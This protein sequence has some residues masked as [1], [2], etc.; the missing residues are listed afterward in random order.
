MSEPADPKQ[1]AEMKQQ[2]IKEFMSL[3]PLTLEIAGLPRVEPGKHFN[4]DQM[5][6]RSTT[7]KTAYKVARGLI[8]DIV[9]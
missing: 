8:I 3:L 6:A 1:Q 5:E 7:L 4:Q 9:K 2:K